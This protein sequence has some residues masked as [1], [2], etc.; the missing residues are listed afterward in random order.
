[1]QSEHTL[2][3][4]R[5]LS[6]LRVASIAGIA[7]GVTVLV[8][9]LG[10]LLFSDPLADKFLK[11]R[12]TTAIAEAYP[13]Y[14]M[15]VGELKYSVLGNR[16]A[17]DSVTLNAADGSFSGRIGPFSVSGIGWM[18]LLWGG[19]L[20]PNDFADA[21]VDA[22]NI[23]LSFSAAQ[24]EL[25]CELL[26]V[27]V[28][29][30]DIVVDILALN[31]LGDDEQFD[32]GSAFRRTRF[33]LDVPNARVIGAACLDL[34]QGEGYRARSVHIRDLFLDVLINKEK[35]NARDTSRP[36][37]P[38][39]LLA[40]IEAAVQIDSLSISNGRLLY[41]ERFFA[42]SAPALITLDSMQ[43]LAEG[44]ANRGDSAA[45]VV[46]HARGQFMK[47]GTMSVLMVLPL[48]S[49]EFSCQYSGSLGRMDLGV[50]NTF[51]EEAEEMRIKAGVLQSATF[52]IH[53]AS[54]HA[55]GTVRAVYRDLTVAAINRRTGSEKG[56]GDGIASFI[57]NTFK[58]RGTNV[59]DETG[60]SAIGEVQYSR[61]RNDVFL[62]YAWFALRS[63]VGDVVGF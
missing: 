43:V 61:K 27:S 6:T 25:R 31:P 11:P 2:S 17:L 49:T 37:M 39:E 50:L 44:I 29:D 54:G 36:R 46:I 45:A 51:L 24:Y 33:R 3:D 40:S 8:C 14:A 30:S 22:H 26:R 59:P 7:V 57:A 13:A 10:L 12:I 63:G 28:P 16:F 21:V 5:R 42:G 47:A 4:R 41:G 53:V 62:S 35:P 23:N 48:A 34:L 56:F 9:V 15:R 55:S 32:A 1:M 52:D 38:N 60:L 58:I 20:A 18:H 19:T